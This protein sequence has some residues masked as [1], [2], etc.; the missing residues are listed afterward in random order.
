MP[1]VT[2]IARA[3]NPEVA[4]SNPARA[5][6]KPGGQEGCPSGTPLSSFLCPITQR[7]PRAVP[8]VNPQVSM[9]REGSRPPEAKTQRFAGG[10]R[11]GVG[12]ILLPGKT[13]AIL[14]RPDPCP[15]FCPT[16]AQ[17]TDGLDIGRSTSCGLQSH[18]QRH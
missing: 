10:M 3:H 2:W 12:G 4:G 14:A 18:G 7:S 8:G 16:F 9:L 15:D 1:Q 6:S 13:I 17:V 5:T 11:I